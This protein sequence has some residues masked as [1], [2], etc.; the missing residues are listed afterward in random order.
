M[1]NMDYC[2]FENTYNAID[3]C[4][5]ALQELK[6][7]SE[8][9]LDYAHKIAEQ[10]DTFKAELERYESVMRKGGYRYISAD[11]HGYVE[12]SMNRE[13]ATTAYHF[14]QCDE[15]AMAVAQEPY[16]QGQFAQVN[17]ERLK[18]SLESCGISTEGTREE[19]ET[20]CVFMAAGMW[21]DE[22]L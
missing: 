14:G 22:Y 3:E 10:L 9:E 20:R 19:L 13:M 18:N 2:K 17:D 5:T 6:E 16:M 1:I 12:L 4:L 7:V 11:P 8:G 15:D 21:C